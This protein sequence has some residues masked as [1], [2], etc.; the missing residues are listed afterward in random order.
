MGGSDHCSLLTFLE[1]VT[2]VNVLKK[3]RNLNCAFRRMTIKILIVLTFCENKQTRP[4]L[5]VL[6]NFILVLSPEISRDI[7][8]YFY[9]I[10]LWACAKMAAIVDKVCSHLIAAQL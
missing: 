9:S 6:A 10:N 1:A 7:Y 3:W 8:F 2:T 5:L 4:R